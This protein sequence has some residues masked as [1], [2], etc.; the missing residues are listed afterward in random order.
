MIPSKAP[1]TPSIS[2]TV[3]L[4]PQRLGRRCGSPGWGAA[5]HLT[6]IGILHHE[7]QAVMGLE[8]VLQGLWDRKVARV[9]GGKK[10]GAL[11]I[12]QVPPR[13]PG[14]RGSNFS[15]AFWGT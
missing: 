8:G 11:L 12:L 2:P 14:S 10:A 7:A 4:H 3:P 1:S 6:T 9:G 13:H 15:F 5:T